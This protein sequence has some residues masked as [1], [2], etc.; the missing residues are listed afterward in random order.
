M[1]KTVTEYLEPVLDFLACET[2][3]AWIAFASRED[4]LPALLADHAN[5]ELKAAQT[6]QALMW[7]Y[8]TPRTIRAVDAS[9]GQATMLHKLSRLAREELRH[10]EQVLN[11][12]K[13]LSVPYVAVPASRYAT[14]MIEAAA[15]QEPQALVDKLIIGAFI[16]ARSCERFAKLAPYLPAQVAAFYVSLLKSESRHFS[17][18]L[19]LAETFAGQDITERVAHFRQV[20]Q[21]LVLTED[22][23]F[24]FHSGVPVEAA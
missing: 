21:R 16:E 10:F 15:K 23:E 6:A 20:E 7:R 2:P 18:Y 4:Q 22:A 13:K 5:C 11:I 24:R 17:D 3:D 1:A 12:M 9:G 8:G 19:A 14:G